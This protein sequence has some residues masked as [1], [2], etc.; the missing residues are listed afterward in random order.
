MCLPNKTTAT[1]KGRIIRTPQSCNK[2][3]S[4]CFQRAVAALVVKP[5]VNLVLTRLH[6]PSSFRKRSTKHLYSTL[7]FKF[8]GETQG[9]ESP[10]VYRGST[11]RGREYD[12][13]NTVGADRRVCPTN[14]SANNKGE[15]FELLS[16]ATSCNPVAFS[17]PWLHSL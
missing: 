17:E 13:T 6:K 5:Q 1:Q 11:R 14:N 16:L 8:K 2:L 9:L 3:Q 4:S 15:R 7:N 12:S 10:S